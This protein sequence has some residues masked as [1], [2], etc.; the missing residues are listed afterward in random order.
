MHDTAAHLVD[1]VLPDVPYRQWVLSLP[2]PLR[3]LLAYRPQ[4]LRPVLQT[5]LRAVFA[6]QRRHARRAGIVDGRPGAVTFIQRFGSSLNLNIHFH[7]LLPDG[8]FARNADGTVGFVPI[9]P[10]SDDE[11]LAITIKIYRRVTALVSKAEDAVDDSEDASA[12]LY[13]DAVRA[14]R[15]AAQP[16]VSRMLSRRCALVDG[17]SLH[18]NVHVGQ[19]HPTGLELLCRYGARPPLALSRL[20]TLPDGRVVY[21]FKR[22]LPDG[23]DHLALAPIDFLAKLAALVPPPRI[24]LVRYHGVFAPNAKDRPHVIPIPAP[25]TSAGEPEPAAPRLRE[26]R[27]DWAALLRR[28]FAVDVLQ[29]PLCDGRMK[30]VSFITDPLVA[31]RILD[32]LGLPS[33]QPSPDAAR[34]PPDPIVDGDPAFDDPTS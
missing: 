27:L 7:A 24:H 9:S 22:A 11:I 25:A 31:R 1:R 15:H 26:R 14:Q 10:P 30:V 13:A 3:F 29:C 32:H 4:F 8:V 17:F 21:R 28:V 6:W 33:T 18:A 2:R 19:G 16:A 12:Q 34:A 20:S 5:F 23:T